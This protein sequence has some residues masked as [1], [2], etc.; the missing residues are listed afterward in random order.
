MTRRR[1][2]LPTYSLHKGSGQAM[3]QLR[4]QLTGRR[5]MTYL[6]K[7]GSPESHS[8]YDRAMADWLGA[9]RRVFSE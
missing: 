9:G 2:D 1:D 4:D 7:F 5:S 3:V 6:G 8:E